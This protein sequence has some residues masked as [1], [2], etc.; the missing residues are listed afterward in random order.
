MAQGKKYEPSERDRKL[1]ESY[2]AV[3]IPQE[4]IAVTLKITSKTLRKHYANE[5]DQGQT[6]ANAAVGGTLFRM[7]TSGECPAATIFWTKTR[8]G[9]REKD[10]QVNENQKTTIVFNKNATR[11]SLLKGEVENDESEQA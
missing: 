2:T 6:K 4:D 8:M 9:W 1:V 10:A 3:G 5:L 7:A 11:A